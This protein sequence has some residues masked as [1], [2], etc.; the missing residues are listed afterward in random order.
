MTH[1]R[2]FKLSPNNF[3][4]LNRTPWAGERISQIK[5]D[6]RHNNIPA[7]IGESWEVSTDDE[8]PSMLAKPHNART[9]RSAIEEH[10]QAIL[11]KK[12]FETFGAHCPILLKWIEA[13]S[14]LSV[15]IH[16]SHAHAALTHDECGKPEAWLVVATKPGACLYVGFN[17]PLSRDDIAALIEKNE[18]ESALHRIEPNPLD[19]VSIPAGCVHALGPDILIIEPQV[20][21]RGKKGLTWR[22]SDWGRKYNANG[23]EDPHGAP[24]ELHTQKALSAINT[25]LP[26]GHEGEQSF[27]RPLTHALRFL[28]NAT[29]P[30]AAQVYCEPGSFVRTPLVA[31]EFEVVTA[32]GGKATLLCTES[33]DSCEL[34]GGESALV[35]AQV[36]QTKL[37]LES[38]NNTPPGLV[39]FSLSTESAAWRS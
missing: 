26:Q 38:L 29:N 13:S 35:S 11:G 6:H 39:F 7:R 28:G 36:T 1:Q 37:T 25:N 15:Q 30:F 2:F 19:F 22:M 33:G 5:K 32:W 16:P 12:T 31:G 20:I 4:P 18:L 3:T 10:P 9:L 24:R 23:L 34:M 8:F 17:A 21:L 14:P 27:S